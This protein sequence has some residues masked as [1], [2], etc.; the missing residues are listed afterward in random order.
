MGFMPDHSNKV[1]RATKQ[2]IQNFWFLMHVK[3]LFRGWAR[4]GVVKSMHSAVAAQGFMGSDPGCRHGIA[5]Q[6][7]FR[8]R[9]T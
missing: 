8:Q 1:N 2:V 9:P 3:T 6:I 4:G 7:M 5:R